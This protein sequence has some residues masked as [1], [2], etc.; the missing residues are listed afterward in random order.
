MKKLFRYKDNEPIEV[1]S[2]DEVRKLMSK[3]YGIQKR[4]VT[5]HPYV[6]KD[7]EFS[8]AVVLLTKFGNIYAL[9]GTINFD[10]EEK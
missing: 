2:F 10:P 1:N 8:R 4:Q 3:K 7:E 6:M 9:V 5:V